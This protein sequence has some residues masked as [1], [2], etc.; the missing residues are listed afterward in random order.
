MCFSRH[1]D[2]I[3]RT[4]A[5]K[6]TSQKK[7]KNELT[8]D[9]EVYGKCILYA[10]VFLS[11]CDHSLVIVIGK[12]VFVWFLS[13]STDCETKEEYNRSHRDLTKF[14]NLDKTICVLGDDCANSIVKLQ[15]DH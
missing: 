7:G 2:G 8:E 6:V 9:G 1:S 12:L 13:Q 15:D 4:G 11:I 5:L 10:H 3:L 14:L